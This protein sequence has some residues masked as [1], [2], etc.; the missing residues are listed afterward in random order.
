MVQHSYELSIAPRR[1][2]TVRSELHAVA[3]SRG[4][5]I[6]RI[7]TFVHDSE[8]VP[9]GSRVQSGVVPGITS[10]I[11]VRTSNPNLHFSHGSPLSKPATTGSSPRK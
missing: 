4:K 11:I 7:N 9:C 5:V 2:D 10:S 1:A 6:R 3:A 8:I